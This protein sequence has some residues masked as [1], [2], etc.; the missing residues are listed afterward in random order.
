MRPKSVRGASFAVA[1]AV[2]LAGAAAFA[3]STKEEAKQHF[4]AGNALVENEDYSAAAAEL[5]L[6]VQ[7]FPTKM[8]LFNLAN[9]YK[10]LNRYGDALE[11]LARLER[12]FAGKLGTLSRDVSSLKNTIE[13]MVGRLA[14]KVDKDGAA[15]RVD[16]A[17][18]GV[19]PLGKTL[20]LA[21]G[22]HMI[23][24]KLSGYVD[25]SQTVRIVSRETREMS[26]VLAEE[27]VA[28]PAPVAEPAAP[29]PPVPGPSPAP[30]PRQIWEADVVAE[31]SRNNLPMD[32]AERLRTQTEWFSLRGEG[33]SYGGG[34]MLNLFDVRWRWF[35]WEILRVSGGGGVPSHGDVRHWALLGTAIGLPIHFG[36]T[37]RHELRIGF[38]VMGGT[39][40]NFERDLAADHSGDVETYKAWSLG[41]ILVPEVSYVFHAARRFALQFGA[42]A[43]LA[44]LYGD[45]D[46]VDEERPP[47]MFNGFLGFRI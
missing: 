17:E 7:L 24:A 22:D 5:E 30:A 12:E 9:C 36:S 6:S 26:F 34:G 23:E 3:A 32:D 40:Y 8:G 29:A 4:D 33:G 21:P 14:V 28:P 2:S 43:Y 1:L 38:G 18:I 19:S 42:G 44:T 37:G 39:M 41:P 10:A 11:A 20:V 15:I 13:G 45:R 47:P 25:A 31:S 46:G 16:G 27:P 35:Y